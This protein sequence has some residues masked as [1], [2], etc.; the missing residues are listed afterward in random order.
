MGKIAKTYDV[1]GCRSI[2]DMVQIA[3][4]NWEP[5]ASSFSVAGQS[6]VSGKHRAI[7]RSDTHEVLGTATTAYAPNGHLEHMLALQPMIESGALVPAN[8]AVWDDGAIIAAQFAT[9]LEAF[10]VKRFLTLLTRNDSAGKDLVL[11]NSVRAFCKNQMAKFRA[12]SVGGCVH[13]GEI[14]QDYAA[15]ISRSIQQQY[16]QQRE[17]ETNYSRMI[18]TKVSEPTV[19]LAI[20][21]ILGFSREETDKLPKTIKEAI[22]ASYEATVQDTAAN[23]SARGDSVW[24]SYN[25]ATHY[26]THAKGRSEAA[27]SYNAIVGDGPTKAYERA[28]AMVVQS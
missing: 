18:E 5:V 10:G 17:L 20:G 19:R 25:A 15:L 28:L 8:V 13:K 6:S 7:V 16:D 26:L 11:F 3:D 14:E 9:G 12:D 21:N 24:T 1:S 2:T 23:D 27:R 4:L 22:Y